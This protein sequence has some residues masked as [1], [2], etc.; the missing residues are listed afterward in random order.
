MDRDINDLISTNNFIPTP[1]LTPNISKARVNDFKTYYEAEMELKKQNNINTLVDTPK[2]SNVKY[3]ESTE[4]DNLLNSNPF[5]MQD[6]T[7][8]T[9]YKRIKRDVKNIISV[10]TRDRNKVLYSKPNN[11][12]M[13][14][15][16][17]FYNVKQISLIAIEFPNTDAV[18]NSS[19]NKIY[20]RNQEDIDLDYTTVIKGVTMYPI[21]SVDLRIGSYTISSLQAE[22]TSKL[23]SIKRTQGTSNGSLNLLSPYHYFVVR[24]DINTDIV[25]FT[26]LILKQTPNNPLTTSSGNGIII[27]D[28]SGTN[29][30]YTNNQRIYIKGAKQL[31]GIAASVINDFFYITVISSTKFSF[32]VNVNASSTATGGGN[33]IQTGQEAPFKLLWG[34]YNSTVAQNIGYPLEDS[35]Q[36]IYTNI[37]NT[38]IPLK[39]LENI[40]QMVITTTINHNFI[41]SYDYISQLIYIGYI[42]TGVFVELN[43]I[44]VSSRYQIMDIPGTNTILVQ[45]V[46]DNVPNLLNNISVQATTIKFITT[47]NVEQL[48]TIS[49]YTNYIINSFLVSTETSHN[50]NLTHIGN[51][52]TLTNTLDETVLND[53]NYDGN[54][55]IMEVPSPSTLI[56]PGIISDLNVHSNNQYGQI[57]RHTPITTSIVY[58]QNISIN[59]LLIGGK[60]YTLV[61]TKTDHNLLVGDSVY[62]N[63]IPT[64]PILITAKVITSVPSSNSFY[65]QMEFSNIDL[66]PIT[67]GIAFIGTGL[68][69]VSFPSHSFNTITNIT[70]GSLSTFGTILSTTDT[71]GNIITSGNIYS[72]LPLIAQTIT[73][74]N[75][76]V[77]GGNLRFSNTNFGL[78]GPP[79]NGANAGQ[80]L[81]TNIN[82]SDTFSFIKT[83][84]SFTQGSIVYSTSGS[85]SGIL[86]LSNDFFLYNV[87][88]IGGIDSTVINNNLFSVRE[89]IDE[90]TFTFMIPNTYATSNEVDG[91]SNVYISSLKHG[92]SGIQTNT[93][94]NNLNRSINLEGENYTFLTCPTLNTLLNTGSVDNV[95]ARISLNKSP[96]NICFDFLSNPKIFNKTPLNKLSELEF[97]VVNYNNSLYEFFDL[98]FSFTLEITEVIDETD[99]FNI[100]SRRGIIDTN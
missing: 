4:Q 79:T 56:L 85:I 52:I 55:I 32:Q 20:W 65:I 82:S 91:G 73:N 33:T 58:I 92:F 36:V 74:H 46:D 63:N 96:G 66:T 59:H 69:T 95:F 21:Y 90:N 89:I 3:D 61:I 31:A 35:S 19:N 49:S 93:K 14:L 83:P 16:K 50:Y 78:D 87:N 75:F 24:L 34:E 68:I 84:V 11:F 67:L 13:F 6:T 12:K 45:I 72:S 18:I 94:N 38:I 86:G 47:S 8:D 22:I 2:I 37:S 57:S 76:V 51:E 26:S 42:D 98:D 80:Y 54:Y 77:T 70:Y 30:G 1:N 5:N 97:S 23:N 48:F 15:N 27:V 9:K 25:T 17:D 7:L 100:S 81:L 40:S 41:R 28:F 62:F 44:T 88:T 60:Y 64:N 29:H 43:S 39:S 99:A 53:P 71:S 10:D